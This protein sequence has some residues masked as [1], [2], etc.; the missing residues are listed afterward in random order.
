MQVLAYKGT[1]DKLAGGVSV[2]AFAG[3]P[4]IT[5][6]HIDGAAVP[7]APHLSGQRQTVLIGQIV[8][9][10]HQIHAVI[11]SAHR[12]PGGIAC[13][14]PQAQLLKLQAEVVLLGAG[15]VNKQHVAQ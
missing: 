1:L 9:A 7:G 6:H 10:H 8:V 11:Q 3:I 2:G 12:I 5:A 14:D 4:D 13:G 15:A